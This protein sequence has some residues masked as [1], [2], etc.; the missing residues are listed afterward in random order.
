MHWVS[1]LC[2][3]VFLNCTSLGIAKTMVIRG[4]RQVAER[5]SRSKILRCV[6]REKWT[7]TEISN[8][9]LSCIRF[10]S[11]HL[12]NQK[13]DSASNTGWGKTGSSYSRMK[14]FMSMRWTWNNQH[15]NRWLI[16]LRA[17]CCRLLCQECEDKLHEMAEN[18]TTYQL[19]ATWWFGT[20]WF[21]FLRSPYERELLLQG[22]PIESQSIE[23]YHY[24][25]VPD[26]KLGSMVRI[27]G[28][29][30]P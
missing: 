15:F 2:V 25:D 30:L 9:Q 14:H 19:V 5:C 29:F 24:L 6:F 10:S 11:A 20:Q 28:L 8:I 22:S 18:I 13:T 21:G 27:S 12:A 7:K 3:F 4:C 1:V 17:G 23:P 26:R 16:I